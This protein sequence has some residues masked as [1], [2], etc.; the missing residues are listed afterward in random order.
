LNTEE[1][2]LLITLFDHGVFLCILNLS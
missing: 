1:Y 2:L